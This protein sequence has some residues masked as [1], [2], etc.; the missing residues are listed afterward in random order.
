MIKS[1][2]V[3]MVLMMTATAVDAG[4]GGGRSGG[5]GGGRSYGGSRYTAPSRPAAR[6]NRSA[7]DSMA[8]ST[9][10][11]TPY[12]PLYAMYLLLLN[13]HRQLQDQ[14]KCPKMLEKCINT[15]GLWCTE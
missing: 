7:S 2:A 14:E 10:D 8:R 12:V 11:P 15:C 1:I 6:T 5:F 4:F 9:A 3:G 13:D